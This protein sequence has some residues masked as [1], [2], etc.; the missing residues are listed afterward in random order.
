MSCKCYKCGF[1]YGEGEEKNHGCNGQKFF[2]DGEW[3]EPVK[4]GD[5][6]DWYEGESPE[7]RCHDCGAPVGTYHHGSCDNERCPV[8][9]GQLWTCGCFEH[10]SEELAFAVIDEIVKLSKQHDVSYK[11]IKEIMKR[12]MIEE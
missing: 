11:E 5:P 6:G 1:D 3:Y 12:F 9:G 10:E 7:T 4:V 2:K 8:C